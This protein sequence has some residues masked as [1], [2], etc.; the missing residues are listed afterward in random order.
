MDVCHLLD[1]NDSEN[2]SPVQGKKTYKLVRPLLTLCY[3]LEIQDYLANHTSVLNLTL[4][5]TLFLQQIF[6]FSFLPE[7]NTNTM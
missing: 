7:R 2:I 6:F 3:S 1:I 4:F 5:L